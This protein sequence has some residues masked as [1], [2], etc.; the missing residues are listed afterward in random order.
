MSEGGRG[1]EGRGGWVT[2][3]QTDRGNFDSLL[4]L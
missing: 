1:G 2:K 3:T 4:L